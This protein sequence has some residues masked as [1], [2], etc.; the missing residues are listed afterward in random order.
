MNDKRTPDLK[1][2]IPIV[3]IVLILAVSAVIAAFGRG[4]GGSYALI[5]SNGEVIEKIELAASPDRV[6]EVKS[7]L[8]YNTVCIKDGRISVI[9]ADCADKT[10]IAMG[11]LESELMPIVCLPHRLIISLTEK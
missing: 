11:E 6:F 3:A 9:D 5:T 4:R 8:G 1:S 2:R 7:E 10:C